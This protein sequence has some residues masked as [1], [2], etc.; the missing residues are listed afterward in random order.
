MSAAAFIQ[1]ARDAG[2][3]LTI[4]GSGSIKVSGRRGAVERLAPELAANKTLILAELQ[5]PPSLPWPEPAITKD[6]NFSFGS[7]EVPQ[8]YR[9]AWGALL[10]TCPEGVSEWVWLQAIYAARDLFGTWG[11]KIQELGW[12]DDDLFERPD[13]LR[14]ADGDAVTVQ[15]PLK[16]E[17]YEKDASSG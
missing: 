2:L 8:R 4:S 9:R 6:P 17:L 10:R 12:Y 5:P 3:T 7:D 11:T 16:A 13:G 1:K 14:L 15:G